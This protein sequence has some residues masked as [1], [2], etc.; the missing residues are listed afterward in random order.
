MRAILITYEYAMASARDAAN[1]QMRKAGRTKWNDDDW[2][3]SCEVFNRLWPLVTHL[4]R[5]AE[6]EG[7]LEQRRQERARLYVAQKA[8]TAA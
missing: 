2:N 4:A 3:K 5:L 1:A 7:A 8:S 6:T